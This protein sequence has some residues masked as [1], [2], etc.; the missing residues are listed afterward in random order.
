LCADGR[1][2]VFVKGAPEL[3]LELCSSYLTDGGT[4]TM[5][6]E[7][8][9]RIL[10]QSENMAADALRVLGFA[11]RED[12]D[13]RGNP[14]RG[15]TFVGLAGLYDPPRV[16]AVRAVADCR[17][18]HI[19]PVMITGDHAVTARA[20]ATQLDILRG[21]DLVVTGEEMDRM[22]EERLRERCPHTSVFARVTPAHKLRIVRAF[23]SRGEV[24]AMTGDGVN[25]APALKEASIGV[26]MGESGTDVT[27]EAAEVILLDDNFATLV[28]AIEEGRT[29]YRNIRR[30]LRYLLSCNC[31]EVITMFFGMLMG[32]PVILTPIQLL[33]VN[34]VTDGLPA[35]ALG[36][37]P[38]EEGTMRE[39]PRA[40][41]ESIFANGLLGRILFRGALIGLTTLGIFTLFADRSASLET[42][43]TGALATLIMTQLFHV[44]ECRSEHRG[45]LEMNPCSNPLLLLAV[46]LSLSATVAAIYVP[47]VAHVFETTILTR[48]QLLTVLLCS[49]AVPLCSSLALMFSRHVWRG[50]PDASSDSHTLRSSQ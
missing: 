41:S 23:K 18:A 42:A 2:R 21:D 29:I 34:L 14:E 24:V 30:F 33:L 40:A 36:L 48:S 10:R 5:T 44:F 1:R 49:G 22:T 46:L 45:I 35:I 11:F 27:R 38:T 7:G 17:M 47:A 6:S 31:G 20:I 25:D 50:V 43:R 12:N 16:E 19:K 37:E 26:A 13:A 8:R 3:L 9:R 39:R 15:L 4:Y 32:M 28:A